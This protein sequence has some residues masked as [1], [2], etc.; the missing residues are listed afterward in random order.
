MTTCR[1]FWNNEAVQY[2]PKYSVEE[3]EVN[4]LGKVY[5]IIVFDTE[6][7]NE[8]YNSLIEYYWARAIQF[9][10]LSLLFLVS[11]KTQLLKHFCL[12]IDDGIVIGV[13]H[14]YSIFP[15]HYNVS[16]IPCCL[17]PFLLNV[18]NLD[19]IVIQSEP[20]RDK[21]NIYWLWIKNWQN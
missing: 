20:L 11:G 19:L 10:H 9:C 2:S 17:L 16:L 14:R 6:V 1:F 12:V 15:F 4:N 21:D 8:P 5:L 3:E 18:C 13:P 7:I